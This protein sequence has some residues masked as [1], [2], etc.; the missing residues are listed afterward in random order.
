[1]AGTSKSSKAGKGTKARG[2]RK[3]LSDAELEN[4]AGGF[5]ILGKAVHDLQNKMH[6]AKKDALR[7]V[8]DK[9]KPKR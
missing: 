2:Q 4:V 7:Q 8:I 5:G 6:G 1:M 9:I 3:E